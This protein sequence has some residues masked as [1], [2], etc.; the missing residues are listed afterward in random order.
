MNMRQALE[1]RRSVYALSNETTLTENNLQE[2]IEHAVNQTPSAFNSQTSRVVVLHNDKHKKLWDLTT[3]ALRAI[4]P[5]DAFENSKE[6]IDTFKK[7]YATILYFED[8]ATV[9]SL[10]AQ[11][12]IYSGNFPIW[13]QQSSGMLQGNIWT[14][15]A[16]EGMGASLQHYNELIEESVKQEWA[17]ESQWKLIAQ[18][19]IGKPLTD[20]S[21]K[22]Y[23][24]IGSRVKVLK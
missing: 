22:A 20:A 11:F 9:K 23:M 8:M 21:E 15:L 5:E 17:L 4:M 6:K 2:L 1:K 16:T 18:M 24:P 12:P 19:P 3:D 14:L 10:Q 13:S 7:G